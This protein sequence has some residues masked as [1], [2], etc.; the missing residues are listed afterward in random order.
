M[1]YLFILII[2]SVIFSPGVLGLAIADT[3]AR[4]GRP[5]SRCAALLDAP[6]QPGTFVLARENADLRALSTTLA[7][8][9]PSAPAASVPVASPAPPLRP[10][11]AATTSPVNSW[12][13]TTRAAPALRQA[14]AEVGGIPLHRAGRMLVVHVHV[15]EPFNVA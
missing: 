11:P 4:N 14:G 8:K 15:I 9:V 2:L 3:L 6:A 5:A 13:A 7:A 10:P 1:P 12:S